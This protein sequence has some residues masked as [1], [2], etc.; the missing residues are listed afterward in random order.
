MIYLT[1]VYLFLQGRLINIYALF[2]LFLTENISIKQIMICYRVKFKTYNKEP[3]LSR[4]SKLLMI[5]DRDILKKLP[6]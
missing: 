6:N 1:Q 4:H 5:R 3:V 2:N